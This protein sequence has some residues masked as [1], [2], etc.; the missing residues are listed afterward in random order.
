MIDEIVVETKEGIAVAAVVYSGI[1]VEEDG[2]DIRRTLAVLLVLLQVDSLQYRVR[3][4]VEEQDEPEAEKDIPAAESA[5]AVVAEFEYEDEGGT[6][7]TEGLDSKLPPFPLP[8]LQLRQQP[9]IVR[10]CGTNCLVVSAGWI[11]LPQ[12]PLPPLHQ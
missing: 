8:R 2:E 10:Y 5:A 3:L 1:G 7:G 12:S 11:H 4:A 9:H 6:G